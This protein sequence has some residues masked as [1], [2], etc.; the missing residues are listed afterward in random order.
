MAIEKAGR[1]YRVVYK[2][3][4]KI[5]RESF[6]T[7]ALAQARDAAIKAQKAAGTFSPAH[8]LQD[9]DGNAVDYG[10][11]LTVSEMIGIVFT[12]Y[13]PIKWSPEVTR[14]HRARYE[15]FIKSE[16][17][18]V[19]I[20]DLSVARVER[21]LTWCLT[22][23]Q[24]DDPTRLTG[25]SA[26]EKI[27]QLLSIMLSEA[28]RLQYI[29][30]ECSEVVKRA[31][32]VS[33]SSDEKII[34]TLEE[35]SKALAV[36]ETIQERVLIELS[37][38]ASQRIGETAGLQWDDV[39]FLPDG[40]VKLTFRQQLRRLAVREIETSKDYEIFAEIPSGTTTKDKCPPQTKLVLC[41][42]KSRSK[43]TPPPRV[44]YVDSDIAGILYEMR[45]RQE[46]MRRVLGDK[47]LDMGFVL[48]QDNGRPYEGN[49]VRKTLNGICERAGI[50]RITP[51]AMRH[52][53]ISLKEY[54]AAGDVSALN[55]IQAETGQRNVQMVYERYSHVFE[56]QK[57]K[58]AS[59][60][61]DTIRKLGQT[62]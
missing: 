18:N 55:V 7:E 59:T 41:R 33:Y 51:H 61:Q 44:V 4:G 13:A 42:M 37:A 40:T 15:Y 47:Y 26:V 38:K 9:A 46:L 57:K 14:G 50:T 24:T 29:D 35:Y 62:S 2:W 3:K 19:R 36:C 39:E 58:M 27:K 12:D 22:Q 21:F 53:S 8:E 49:L 31:R 30:R 52:W 6:Q 25:P 10:K 5:Y 28:Y 23:P 34:W 45:D 1:V 16:L 56:E 20:A 48:A 11:G 54:A 17:G 32:C 60:V 43:C